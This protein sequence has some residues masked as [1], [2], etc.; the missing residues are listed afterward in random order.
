MYSNKH[1]ENQSDEFEYS[2][3][4]E[5]CKSLMLALAN[6]RIT[7]FPLST[8]TSSVWWNESGKGGKLYFYACA[9]VSIQQ[10]PIDN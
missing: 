7:G 2:L 3:D 1:M 5:M 8:T 9:L 6:P 10:T 4:N